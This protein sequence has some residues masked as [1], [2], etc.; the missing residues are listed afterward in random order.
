MWVPE[1]PNDTE[2]WVADAAIIKAAPD[3]L[4]SLQALL[5]IPEILEVLPQATLNDAKEAVTRATL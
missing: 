5:T 3:L 1:P 2:K 4:S